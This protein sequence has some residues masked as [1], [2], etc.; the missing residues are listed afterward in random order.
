[1]HTYSHY[2]L[3]TY[4]VLFQKLSQNLILSQQRAKN[5][6]NSGYL[7]SHETLCLIVTEDF[8]KGLFQTPIPILV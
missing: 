5:H 8:K 6:Q 1:M 2:K 3:G 4:M 7:I